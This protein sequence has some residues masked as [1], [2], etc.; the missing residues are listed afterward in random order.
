[1]NDTRPGAR[2]RAAVLALTMAASTAVAVTVA[3]AP[4]AAAPPANDFVMDWTAYPAADNIPMVKA[5]MTAVFGDGNRNAVLN[6]NECAA[7]KN[8][9]DEAAYPK[10]WYCFDSGDT[11]SFYN[12]PDDGVSAWIPQ[13]VTTTADALDD[14]DWNGNKGIIVGWY[15]EGGSGVRISVLNTATNTYRHVLLANPY[16]DGERYTYK[17]LKGLHA[18]GMAW[19]GDYLYVVDTFYGIRVFDT[20]HIF[21]L[22]ASTN[23][24]TSCSGIGYV[25]TNAN[26]VADKYCASTYKYVMPQVGMWQ[27]AGT[28]GRD[29][30]SAVYCEADSGDSRYSTI[31]IDRDARPRHQL[32]VGEYCDGGEASNGRVVAYDMDDHRLMDGVPDASW[33]LPVRRVQGVASAGGYV[34][35]NQSNTAVNAG[36]LF[37]ATRSGGAL[38]VVGQGL[39]APIGPEA[40]SVW[41]SRS[42]VWSVTEHKHATGNG[43]RMLY[44]MPT[45][46]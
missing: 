42:E 17:A 21:D 5:S 18:G 37:R 14:E 10:Y 46:W 28:A 12:G 24:T 40:L 35:L 19:Y 13:A 8:G 1:M 15:H 25:D 36:R 33:D 23:G 20:K 3:T 7:A 9:A 43:R 31:S 26:G 27:Q 34:F 38:T 39:A 32:V 44:A 45:S 41:R 16:W 11:S 6:G 30:N 22:G 2:L 4:A 29:P